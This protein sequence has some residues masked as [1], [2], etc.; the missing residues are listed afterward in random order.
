MIQDNEKAVLAELL[1]RER[2]SDI[3]QGMVLISRDETKRLNTTLGRA[4]DCGKGPVAAG[5]GKALQD[6][7]NTL[8]VLILAT[9]EATAEEGRLGVERRVPLPTNDTVQMAF[10]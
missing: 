10:L 3:L 4:Q 8:S 9:H 5:V 7:E 1:Q 6:A 2:V